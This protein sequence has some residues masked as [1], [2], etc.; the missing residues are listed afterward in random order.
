MYNHNY[1]HSGQRRDV[2][3]ESRLVVHLNSVAVIGAVAE[4]Q[5]GGQEQYAV[6]VS[7]SVIKNVRFH[8]IGGGFGPKKA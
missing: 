8:R 1:L 3:A 7:V 5:A 4:V 2:V 6:L